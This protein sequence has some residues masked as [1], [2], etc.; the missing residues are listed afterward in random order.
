MRHA[1]QPSLTRIAKSL[2]AGKVP[3]ASIA[4]TYGLAVVMFV[5]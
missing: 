4:S 2:L 1:D 5:V 3:T